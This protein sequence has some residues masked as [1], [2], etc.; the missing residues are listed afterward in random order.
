MNFDN[1][2]SD[3]IKVEGGYVNDSTDRGG[4][5][6]YGITV[7]VARANGYTGEMRDMPVSF[8]RN[9][10]LQDYVIKP[11]FDKVGAI[12]E[13]IATKLID[14]GVN[15]GVGTSAKFLQQALNLFNN[16]QAL[17]LDTAEDG[18]IGPGTLGTLTKFLAI[19]STDGVRTLL[20]LISA[21]QC[22]RYVDI[23]TKDKTQEKFFYG[24]VANRV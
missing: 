15:M 9:L 13:S 5:T 17:Y 7:S 20:K 14:T 3:I 2:I 23:A 21:L 12:S 4:E 19:R 18:A 8:A 1:I 16:N 10:Y 11:G 24:W 22:S 6:N